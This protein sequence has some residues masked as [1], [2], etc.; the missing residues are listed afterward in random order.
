MDTN[1]TPQVLLDLQQALER[2]DLF[3]SYH[4]VPSLH[5]VAQ[6]IELIFSYFERTKVIRLA[7]SKILES[8]WHLPQFQYFLSVTEC[9]EHILANYAKLLD[10]DDLGLSQAMT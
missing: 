3:T 9:L 1:K 10:Q 2:G 5:V 7:S 6:D 4:R 8:G